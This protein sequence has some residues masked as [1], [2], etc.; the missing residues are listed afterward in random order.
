M[1]VVTQK[2]FQNIFG[3]SRR[4]VI[5]LSISCKNLRV[6][7]VVKMH[8][9]F[10]QNTVLLMVKPLTLQNMYNDQLKTLMRIITGTI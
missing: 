1:S 8:K 9:L 7:F 3:N 10:N 6:L 5:S 4:T 2:L